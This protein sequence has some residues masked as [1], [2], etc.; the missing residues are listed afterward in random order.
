LSH[1]SGRGATRTWAPL[2]RLSA[3]SYRPTSRKRGAYRNRPWPICSLQYGTPC[4][5]RSLSTPW[6]C[7]GIRDARACAGSRNGHDARSG[8]QSAQS[9]PSDGP[10][11]PGGRLAQTYPRPCWRSDP[12][13]QPSPGRHHS[14]GLPASSSLSARIRAN[15]SLVSFHSGGPSSPNPSA[16]AGSRGIRPSSR[17]SRS[18]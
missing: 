12:A 9:V 13:P 4:G 8:R 11:G 3:S 10:S 14:S 15:S 5:S 18:M 2:P 7:V 6:G 17:C 16:A 1:G